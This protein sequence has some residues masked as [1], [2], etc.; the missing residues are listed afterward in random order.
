[1]FSG[2]FASRHSAES[3]GHRLD[4]LLNSS[5]HDTCYHLRYEAAQG[6]Q[7]QWR[8]RDTGIHL[9]VADDEAGIAGTFADYEKLDPPR[10]S[11]CPD[12]CRR[13]VPV[14]TVRV[15]SALEASPQPP[16]AAPATIVGQGAPSGR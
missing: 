12:R 4:V 3:G 1:M 10:D 8:W 2:V 11:A 15:A 7:G 9:Y 13:H 14:T 5:I 16:V 6:S